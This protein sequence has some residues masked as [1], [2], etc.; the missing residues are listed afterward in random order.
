MAG[1][2]ITIAATDGGSFDS[3]V[4]SPESR[5]GAGVIIVSTISGVDNDMI[6]YADALAA[7]GFYVRSRYVLARCGPGPAGLERRRPQA[8]LRSERP[9]RP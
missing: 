1:T 7:E 9:I 5:R 8:R 2:H 6:Y 3:Y 4:A